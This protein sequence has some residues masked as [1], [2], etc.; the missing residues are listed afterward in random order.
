MQP[1]I[2]VPLSIEPTVI[3]SLSI[4]IKSPVVNGLVSSIVRVV[5]TAERSAV[6]TEPLSASEIISPR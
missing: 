6:M 1:L 4:L 3:Y 2:E 5:A